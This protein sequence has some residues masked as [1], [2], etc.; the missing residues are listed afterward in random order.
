MLSS[1][2]AA[3]PVASPLV[4]AAA[5]VLCSASCSAL[6][7]L[8]ECAQVLRQSPEDLLAFP[9]PQL[10]AVCLSLH[11]CLAYGVSAARKDRCHQLH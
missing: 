3:A 10:E 6:Y 1:L 11:C 7:S 4:G 8:P 2:V 9:S 5:A